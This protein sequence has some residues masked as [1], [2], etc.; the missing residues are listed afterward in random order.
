MQTSGL[1]PDKLHFETA[2]SLLIWLLDKFQAPQWS[3]L[4][5][6]Q[7]EAPHV[8]PAWYTGIPGW[9]D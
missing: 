8:L 5:N 2:L 9:T 3:L 7:F 4:S 6:V 1:I